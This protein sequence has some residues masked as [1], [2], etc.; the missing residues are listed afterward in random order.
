MVIA[1]YAVAFGAMYSAVA[2]SKQNEAF[3]ANVVC[4]DLQGE[5]EVRLYDGTRVDCLSDDYAVELDFGHKVFECHAQAEYYA[6]M[7]DRIPLC[8]L[9]DP[10]AVQVRRYMKLG[11]NLLC[12][13]LR[14]KFVPCRLK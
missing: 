6:A 11:G 4:G 12:V 10:S 2:E 3:Y 8:V 13:N 1:L 9:I 14:G 7:T 5:T